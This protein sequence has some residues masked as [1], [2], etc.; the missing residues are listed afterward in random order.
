MRGRA[1]RL[2]I[3]PPRLTPA[4]PPYSTAQPIRTSHTRR[5]VPRSKACEC[6]WSDGRIRDEQDEAAAAVSLPPGGAAQVLPHTWTTRS[7]PTGSGPVQDSDGSVCCSPNHQGSQSLSWTLVL[8]LG[9]V[10]WQVVL[11]RLLL[12]KLLQTHTEQQTLINVN[13]M[14]SLFYLFT[15]IL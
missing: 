12:D 4:P 13:K 5:G 9:P 10:S 8:V 1:P 11:Q 15:V 7:G 3:G 6:E 2:L 14:T